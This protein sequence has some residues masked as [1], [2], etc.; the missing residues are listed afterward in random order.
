VPAGCSPAALQRG[1]G[2]SG[3]TGAG[4]AGQDLCEEGTCPTGFPWLLSGSR[5][6]VEYE[7]LASGAVFRIPLSSG[8]LS[9]ALMTR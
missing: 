3:G 4:L 8:W 2:W 9:A 1:G 6:K 5:I 7:Y